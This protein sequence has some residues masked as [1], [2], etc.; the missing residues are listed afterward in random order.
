MNPSVGCVFSSRWRSLA[1]LAGSERA[2]QQQKKTTKSKDK[3][4]KPYINNAILGRAVERCCVTFLPKRGRQWS[5]SC[6]FVC[7][8]FHVWF[9]LLL[10]LLLFILQ[11]FRGW[12]RSHQNSFPCAVPPFPATHQICSDVASKCQRSCVTRYTGSCTSHVSWVV[13]VFFFLFR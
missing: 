13:C 1:P 6:V 7:L 10:L 2:Q 8:Y 11:L 12:F 3:T 9:L 5:I 4:G